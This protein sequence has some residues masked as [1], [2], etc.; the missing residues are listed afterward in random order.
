MN[1][2]SYSSL[3]CVSSEE[4][5]YQEFCR[6]I[7]FAD[8]KWAKIRAVEPQNLNLH[9][10]VDEKIKIVREQLRD[11]PFFVEHTGLSINALKGL[12]DGLTRIFMD[13][14]GN[15]IVCKMMQPFKR[16]NER[17]AWAKSV[18]GLYHPDGTIKTFEGE[19]QGRIAERPRGSNN[20]GW[21]PIFIPKREDE[22]DARTFGEISPD[23][24][25]LCSMR[26]I[27]VEKLLAYL[28]TRFELF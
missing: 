28:E 20:F 10:L 27:A 25:N 23:E 8:L 16:K 15:E 3:H 19:V 26:R 24:K 13:T 2:L 1:K 21:D 22:N 18:I 5:K 4:E 11:V 6:L 9:I 14:L 7:G 12:P 17:I